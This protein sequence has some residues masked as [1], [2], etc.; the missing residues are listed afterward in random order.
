MFRVDQTLLFRVL[1]G[2]V[3]HLGQLFP[4]FFLVWILGHDFT[5][6]LRNWGSSRSSKDNFLVI[7]VSASRSPPGLGSD[8]ASRSP[9]GRGHRFAQSAVPWKHV[10]LHSL[11]ATPFKFCMSSG[12]FL[13]QF[14]VFWGHF[15]RTRGTFLSIYNQNRAPWAP[16]CDCP[17]WEP[18]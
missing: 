1:R 8:T 5:I 3:E 4:T 12:L 14:F 11:C 13:T 10:V 15:W 18:F 7:I 6:L 9:P 17:F 2:W 16:P